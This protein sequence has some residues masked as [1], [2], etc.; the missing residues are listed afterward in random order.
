MARRGRAARI[1]V[2]TALSILDASS[3]GSDFDGLDSDPSFD[4][5]GDLRE[6]DDLESDV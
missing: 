5:S 3:S 6:D 4:V 2:E 1:N